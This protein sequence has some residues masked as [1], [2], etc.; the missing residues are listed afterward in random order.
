MVLKKAQSVLEYF[1]LF[2]IITILALV[3]ISSFALKG[4][5]FFKKAA[6]K[7]TAEPKG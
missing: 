4:E 6:E 7:I 5:D 1:I 3:S 2:S